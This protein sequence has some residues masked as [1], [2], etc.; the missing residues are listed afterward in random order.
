MNASVSSDGVGKEVAWRGESE[1]AYWLGTEDS[2]LAIR[3]QSPL[4]YR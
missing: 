2:N 3:I 1:R 4:S